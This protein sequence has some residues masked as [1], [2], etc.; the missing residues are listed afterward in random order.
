MDGVDVDPTR[1]DSP[2][3]ARLE[4]RLRE[5]AVLTTPQFLARIPIKGTILTASDSKLQIRTNQWP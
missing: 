4:T 1:V 2:S 5:L 3:S